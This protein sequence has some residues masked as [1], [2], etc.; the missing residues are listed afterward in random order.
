MKARIGFGASR[1]AGPN[2]ASSPSKP[3]LLKRS[4]ASH[5]QQRSGNA[6]LSGWR[7]S[8]SQDGLG[9]WAALFKKGSA[10]QWA[11]CFSLL[12]HAGLLTVRIVDPEGFQQFF[13]NQALEMILV[14]AKSKE[15]PE[16]VQALAQSNLEGGGDAAD[17]KTRASSPMP[18]SVADK[19]GESAMDEEAQLAEMQAQQATLL[20]QTR[21]QIAALERPEEGHE[22]LGLTQVIK[23]AKRRYLLSQL[24]EIERRINEENSR[25]KKRYISPATQESFYAL[26]YDKVR[27][28]I[29]EHGTDNF[30]DDGAQKLYGDLIVEFVIQSTGLV[31]ETTVLQTSG[32]AILDAKTRAIVRAASGFGEFSA[33]MRKHADVVVVV[34]HFSFR[35]DNTL[36]TELESR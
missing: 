8:M 1:H 4:Q 3:L 32:N 34:S 23:E 36:H 30:P 7:W 5:G 22:G 6:A 13:D 11:L 35:H 21:Q 29:E 2:L 27:R 26:Y 12:V 14:N 28:R 19:D 31:S 25:P 18:A 24:A 17:A 10:F 33:E 9:W 16:K 15:R 20:D